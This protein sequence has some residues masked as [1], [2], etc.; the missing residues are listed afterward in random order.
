MEVID[1]L[2]LPTVKVLHSPH[3]PGV[4]LLVH[5][6]IFPLLFLQ[7]SCNFAHSSLPLHVT[8]AALAGVVIIIVRL[9][10][11]MRLRSMGVEKTNKGGVI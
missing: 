1:L 4:M 6:S 8:L 10:S 2:G 7:I 3:I 9:D 5:I 11:Y